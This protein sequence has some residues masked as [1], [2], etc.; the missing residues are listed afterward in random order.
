MAIPCY[1]IM[2][3]P[4]FFFITGYLVI[5]KQSCVAKVLRLLAN[6]NAYAYT[7][8][9]DLIITSTS[10]HFVCLLQTHTLHHFAIASQY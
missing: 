6:Y 1:V 4:F 10:T 3:K 2:F 5:T 7:P 9:V 8:L